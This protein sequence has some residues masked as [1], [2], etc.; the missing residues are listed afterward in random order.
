MTDPSTELPVSE[1][2]IV[3]STVTL[4]EDSDDLNYP[5]TVETGKRTR[6]KNGLEPAS[7]S[8]F[9]RDAELAVADWLTRER[10]K[11]YY[12]NN[13]QIP[14]CVTTGTVV[15]KFDTANLQQ[16]LLWQ[17][18]LSIKRAGRNASHAY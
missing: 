11:E 12:F 10:R 6:G 17:Y 3:N 1:G 4:G 9:A 15:G 8:R 14:R 2:H 16:I 13:V 18:L 7:R 5:S